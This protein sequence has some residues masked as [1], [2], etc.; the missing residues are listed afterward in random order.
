MRTIGAVP[1][2]DFRHAVTSRYSC[3]AY[4]NKP[5]PRETVVSILQ[6]AGQSPSGG[7]LQPWHVRVLTGSALEGLV[8][9]IAQRAKESPEGEAQEYQ[10]YPPRLEEPYRSR[11]FKCGEDLYAALGIPRDDRPARLEQFARNL[12]FFGAPVA[13][14]F[15]VDKRMDRNQWAH[16]GMFMQT[17]MLSAREHGLHTCPQESWAVWL[18]TVADYLDLPEELRLYCGM[19]MGYEDAGNPVNRWRTERAALAEWATLRGF[20]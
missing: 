13:L 16:L 19:A 2:L 6:L 18:P 5:V 11:R 20:E 10:V 4:L 15:A 12:A 17:L 9:R 14:F 1:S 8:T 7:N 3:R